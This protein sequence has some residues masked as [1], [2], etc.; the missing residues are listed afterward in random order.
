MVGV[1]APDLSTLF[2][3]LLPWLSSPVL[4]SSAPLTA[5]ASDFPVQEPP[6]SNLLAEVSTTAFVV[7]ETLP[8]EPAPPVAP[9]VSDLPTVI[10]NTDI[11]LLGYWSD[12]PG[13]HSFLS[14]HYFRFATTF[15]ASPKLKASHFDPEAFDPGYYY[16]NGRGIYMYDAKLQS[17]ESQLS[18]DPVDVV[19]LPFLLDARRY[20]RLTKDQTPKTNTKVS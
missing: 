11:P 17:W 12:H 1:L 8:V 20:F 2:S 3:Q 18:F 15:E 13:S 6:A 19:N 9:V 10:P 7:A 4:S 5:T 16:I 14:R